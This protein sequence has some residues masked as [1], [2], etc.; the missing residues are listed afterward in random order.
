MAAYDPRLTPARPDLAAERLRGRVEAER[1]VA[2]TPMRVTAPTAPLFSRPGATGFASELLM[3]AEF[4]V[5]ETA[6]GLAWGQAARDGYVGYVPAAALAPAG[7]AP[8]HRVRAVRS[9]LYPAPDIKTVPVA[10]LSLDAR[11]RG[12]IE[13]AFLVCA[14]GCVPAV[15]VAEATSA[16]ADWVAVAEAF[17]GTPYLWGGGSAAGIDCSG[18]VQVARHAAGFDCPRDSDMQAAL[19]RPVEPQR[20]QRGDLVFWKGHVGVMLD[21]DRLLHAN[22]HHMACAV[23]PLAQAVSRIGASDAGAPTGFRRLD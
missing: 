6:D 9:T 23:E 14:E 4:E 7:A 20:L 15:H 8:T 17:L 19:G 5:Y 16:E 12:R 11:L 21:S 2:P 18:L 10:H 13:G 3:G 22:A 1:Y